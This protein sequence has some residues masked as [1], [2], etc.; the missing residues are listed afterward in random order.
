VD[1]RVL[2]HMASGQQ[3][4]FTRAQ[5]KAAGASPYQLAGRIRRG[6]WV[7][8]LGDVLAPAGLPITARVRDAAALLDLPGAVLGGPTAAKR[9]GLMPEVERTFV[10]APTKRR[11]P[12]GVTIVRGRLATD[13]VVRV[14]GWPATAPARTVVDC[15]RLLPDDDAVKVLER[16]LGRRLVTPEQLECKVAERKGMRGTPR[17][18]SLLRLAD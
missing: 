5:A 4:V 13:D 9:F 2:H 3:G 6:E 15:M 16:S 12:R 8:V 11:A 17:L 10:V 14:G 7:I 18:L 1:F